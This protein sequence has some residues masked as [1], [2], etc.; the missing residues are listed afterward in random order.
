MR[1]SEQES[2]N[3]YLDKRKVRIDC[4]SR[5]CNTIER[6]QGQNRETLTSISMY[7]CTDLLSGR[8]L[9]NTNDASGMYQIDQTTVIHRGPQHPVK[10][11]SHIKFKYTYT[12]VC[13]KLMTIVSTSV[14]V[15]SPVQLGSSVRSS[16]PQ[17]PSPLE[18]TQCSYAAF[19]LHH[20]LTP[21]AAN[22]SLAHRRQMVQSVSICSNFFRSPDLRQIPHGSADFSSAA[23][24]AG[25]GSHGCHACII[26]GP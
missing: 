10:L 24:G 3:I 25:A 5:P 12:W 20:S 15:H 2:T 7:D 19:P 23:G 16:T 6:T 8:A 1:K 17:P 4:T 18:S 22:A 21:S 11:C 9:T 13:A 26:G 14:T